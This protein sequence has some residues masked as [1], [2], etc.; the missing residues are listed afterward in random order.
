MFLMVGVLPV[1]V[2][3]VLVLHQ[4][5]FKH[6]KRWLSWAALLAVSA[7]LVALLGV[8]GLHAGLVGLLTFIIGFFWLKCIKRTPVS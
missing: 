1:A 4:V 3:V 5:V 7:G 8:G 6:E 2:V